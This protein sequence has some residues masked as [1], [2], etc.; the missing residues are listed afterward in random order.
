MYKSGG[1]TVKIISRT[2]KMLPI[3][4]SS[5]TEWIEFSFTLPA[6]REYLASLVD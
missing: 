5:D 6:F 2:K 4:A 3:A 1:E